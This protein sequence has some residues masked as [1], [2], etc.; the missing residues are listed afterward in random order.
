MRKKK[1]FNNKKTGKQN[2]TCPT[3]LRL[4]NIYAAS[5]HMFLSFGGMQKEDGKGELCLIV[6]CKQQQSVI[7]N[8]SGK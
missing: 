3:M 1:S 8:K 4:E 2:N 6:Y 7:R 5:I